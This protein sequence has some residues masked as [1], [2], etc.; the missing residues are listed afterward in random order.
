V[1]KRTKEDAERTRSAVLDA[2]CKAFLNRGVARATLDDVA[3]L[4]GVTRG[5]I[6]W[7]FRGKLDLFLALND[8]ARLPYEG[9]LTDLIVR[10]EADPT[11]EPLVELARTTEAVFAAME[12]DVDR[13]RL[14]TILHMRCEYVDEM[15]PAFEWLRRA[16]AMLRAAMDRVFDL[17]GGRGCLAACWPPREAATACFLLIT[18]LV[19]AWLRTPEKMRLAKEGKAL[20][21]TFLASVGRRPTLVPQNLP[22]EPKAK[23][24]VARLRNDLVEARILRLPAAT[25]SDIR[26][27]SGN[28]SEV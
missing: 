9:L 8:R 20:M 3:E 26:A 18:G 13:Q 14:L 19:Q 21:R 17:A 15:K 16:D 25:A 23:R 22:P 27:R 10:L 2:A 11:L 24:H 12:S 7:H 5:A 4:A 1:V 28:D 6:Y